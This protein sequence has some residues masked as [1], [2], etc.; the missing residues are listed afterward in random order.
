MPDWKPE[1]RRRLTNLK[2]EP[3]REA[4]IVEEL[5]QHL[6]DCYTELLAGG[7]T[8]AEAE[9][10]TRG[11]GFEA[12]A[13]GVRRVTE[14]RREQPWRAAIV[15]DGVDSVVL[16]GDPNPPK[17]VGGGPPIDVVDSSGNVDC[18]GNLGATAFTYAMCARSNIGPLSQTL[19]TDAFNST[20][21]PYVW[22]DDV[23][24]DV[25]PISCAD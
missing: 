6:A 19:F 13:D 24:I 21:G 5:A 1:I 14:P 3:T 4:A 2:L 11:A 8:A 10:Q 22:F 17:C 15:I 25:A 16:T 9:R 23:I 7:L 20:A 12:H 18:T